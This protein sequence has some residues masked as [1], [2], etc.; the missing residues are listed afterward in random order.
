MLRRFLFGDDIFISYSRRDGAAYATALASELTSPERGLSCF[1]DHWGASASSDLSR[2]VVHALRNSSVFVLVGTAGAASSAMVREELRLF[3]SG[4][5]WRAAR[6]TL[7]VNL[8][9]ALDEVAWNEITGLPRAIESGET[10]AK[11]IPS[12]VVVRL[13]TDSCT[14]ARR[15]QR[16]RWLSI[17]ALVLLV[18][19]SAASSIAVWQA[20]LAERRRTDAETASRT[21]ERNAQLAEKNRLESEESRR[22]AEESRRQADAAT[23]E[24]V[25]KAR[26]ASQ[27]AAKTERQTEIAAAR[28]L[29]A[30]ANLA[31]AAGEDQLAASVLLA[32]SS[33]KRLQALGF[34][35]AS[36]DQ[37]LR[38]GL[39]LLPAPVRLLQHRADVT[40]LAVSPDTRHVA[41]AGVDRVV[42]VWDVAGGEAHSIALQRPLTSMTFSPD[43]RY[44]AT[45]DGAIVQIWGIAEEKIVA[46][47]NNVECTPPAPARW[48]AKLLGPA[49]SADGK[50]LAFACSSRQGEG[51]R[52]ENVLVARVWEAPGW[53]EL[54][55]ERIRRSDTATLSPEGDYVAAA[56]S[57]GEAV[58]I[59]I[60]S[61]ATESTRINAIDLGS[62]S[63]RSLALS[64][65]GR[66]LAVT[67]SMEGS[68]STNIYEPSA[69]EPRLGNIG[70]GALTTFSASGDRV[71]TL[72]GRALRVYVL[73]GQI[74]LRQVASLV[75]DGEAPLL[76]FSHTQRH[77]V[78]GDRRVVR[79][80]RLENLEEVGRIVAPEAVR[81]L[82]VEPSGR[83]RK[84][85]VTD[86]YDADRLQGLFVTAGSGGAV[87]VWE[88]GR[89]ASLSSLDFVFSPD[90]RF[91][92]EPDIRSIAIRDVLTTETRMLLNP[93]GS[94]W[95]VRFSPNGKYVATTV[96]N[97]RTPVV[98]VWELASERQVARVANAQLIAF[99]GDGE[100]MVVRDPDGRNIRVHATLTNSEVGRLDGTSLSKATMALG[101]GGS[102]LLTVDAGGAA[103]VWDARSGRSL[104]RQDES[105]PPG[106]VG[107]AIVSADARYAAMLLRR[108]ELVVLD[109]SQFR[110]LA[111][112]PASAMSRLL[113]FSP[114]GSRIAVASTDGVFIWRWKEAGGMAN[115]KT[116][117]RVTEA[118]F[119][120][121]RYLATA[122]SQ[123]AQVWD[124]DSGVEISR[125]AVL[126]PLTHLG[127][128]TG[129]RYL[130]TFTE[131][132][133][134]KGGAFDYRV[135][136]WLWRPNEMIQRTCERVAA[137][138]TAAE[139]TL[140]AGTCRQ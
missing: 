77:L 2:P 111:R 82:A 84:I 36:T 128:H 135:Q 54:R 83:V 4:S 104:F 115:L 85:S 137:S 32:A 109:L 140:N 28:L 50:R 15:N 88:F 59:V 3:S 123:A 41:T 23:V 61:L 100:H 113:S 29:T 72:D 129:G 78:V 35:E 18:L 80:W 136:P 53:R 49:F 62:T 43:G 96:T 21:A 42:R 20:K 139:A 132:W 122:V 106:A 56:T 95:A 131:R 11:G 120:D 124:T 130:V 5:R 67:D 24:A 134:E 125:I 12:A 38:Q 127:F 89:E 19:V 26:E 74:R 46:T 75:H 102:R 97:S 121:E 33:M 64:A 44:L 51:Q 93:E 27:Q 86:A 118:V 13:V 22:Q 30:Q 52:A 17:A 47:L 65:R 25:A 60:R 37:A 66:Y 10:A 116:P 16:V 92:A 55:T 39:S 101:K 45:S 57:A 94:T 103:V 6:P 69:R 117:G 98:Q 133:D 81:A 107:S 108:G 1:L 119:A 76:R 68:L 110:L 58:S 70:G 114:A 63:V 79:V 87:Q 7:I 48:N 31:R 8:G 9:G 14:Y 73:G 71:I 105:H 112:M 99:S 40:D 34:Q 91:V 126:D 138:L 90:G